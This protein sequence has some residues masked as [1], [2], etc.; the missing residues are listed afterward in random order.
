MIA[1]PAHNEALAALRQAAATRYTALGLPTRRHEQW[2]FTDL[3]RFGEHSGGQPGSVTVPSALLAGSPQF[4]FVDGIF[5]LER[6]TLTGLP[7]GVLAGQI[8]NLA[9]D[10]LGTGFSVDNQAVE[11]L[12]TSLFQDGFALIVPA[13]MVLTQPVEV[14]YI[15]TG[16]AQSHTRLLVEL[17]DNAQATLIERHTGTGSYATTQVSEISLGTG[18]MLN[19][20]RQQAADPQAL[21]LATGAVQLGRD[22]TYKSFSLTTGALLSRHQVMATLAASGGTVHLDG[23][24]LL[25]GEMHADTTTFIDHASPHCA[26][27]ETYRQVLDGHARGVFQGKILVREGAQKTDGFQLNQA[28]MLSDTA[29]INAKPELEIYADDVKCSHGATSGRLDAEA[30]FYLRSRGILEFE[31]R[32]LLVQAFIGATLDLIDHEEIRA[33][34]I[35]LA[36]KAM[37]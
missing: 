6:S 29:E 33:A 35:E 13:N 22:A 14:V 11:A 25:K 7:A 1:A 23:V 8:G 9:G 10:R 16:S 24:H 12:N 20:Y 34:F 21:L 31:A 18:A 36:G 2:R 17:G 32:Q 5:D 4:V 26:S 15:G 3:S 37:T 27:R 19:H 30:L 28:L